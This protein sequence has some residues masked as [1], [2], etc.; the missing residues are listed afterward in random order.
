[1]KLCREA[2]AKLKNEIAV[3]DRKKKKFKRSL[4]EKST[5]NA[6]TSSNSN[7]NNNN[8]DEI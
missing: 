6:V 2:Y 7:G 5:V 8:N 1:M 3:I 4:C